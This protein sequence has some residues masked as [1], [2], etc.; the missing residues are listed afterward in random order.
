MT[1]PKIKSASH[2]SASQIKPATNAEI[3]IWKRLAG[4]EGTWTG[5]ALQRLIA[6]IERNTRTIAKLNTTLRIAPGVRIG[7]S[8]KK[9]IL[10]HDTLI[11]AIQDAI[12]ALQWSRTHQDGNVNQVTSVLANLHAALAKTEGQTT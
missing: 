3:T 8:G 2:K 12:P 1:T 4:E 6:R 11:A 7:P 10:A 9:R 5:N